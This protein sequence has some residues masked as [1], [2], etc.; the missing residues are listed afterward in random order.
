MAQNGQKC[1]YSQNVH[2][3]RFLQT[4]NNECV[5]L[6]VKFVSYK[7]VNLA[8]FPCKMLIF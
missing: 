5:A 7:I 3:F 8:L 1:T 4:D 2:T 6:L